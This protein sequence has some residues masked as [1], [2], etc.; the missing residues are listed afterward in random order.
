MLEE[1]KQQCDFL[2]V[3]LQTDPSIDRPEKNKPVQ[4]LVERTIQLSAVKYVDQILCY[5][6]EAELF[7]LL[8]TIQPD[9]RIVGA[10]YLNKDF[11]GK[12]WCV[13]NG[14]DIFY[15]SREHGYSSTELRNRLK[16]K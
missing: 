9:V 6:T 2:I 16:Q 8:Q 12:D 10:D 5:Q 14:V 11:T 1:A 7:E 13:Q 3:G 15:N 4:S